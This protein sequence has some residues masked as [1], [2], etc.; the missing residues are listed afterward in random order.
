ML[1]CGRM[2]E[3]DRPARGAT[4]SDAD[5]T[6]LGVAPP[7]LESDAESRQRSPVFV[8]SGTSVADVEPAPLPRIALPS[9][10][11]QAAV[12]SEAPVALPARASSASA[13]LGAAERALQF[14]LPRPALWMVLA[15]TL[16]AV[17]VSAG[18]F[19]AGRGRAKATLSARAAVSSAA[20]TGPGSAPQV[21]PSRAPGTPG[22]T[23]TLSSA[24]FDELERRPAES[25]SSREVLA[26]AEGHA[27]R[28]GAAASA[29]RRKLQAHPALAKDPAVQVEL[30]HL[31]DDARTAREALAAM[32]AAEAPVGPDLLYQVW[33][34]TAVRTEATE[35]SR[36][37]VYS[38]DVRPHASP[39]LAV[40]LDLRLADQCQEYQAILPRALKD[41]DRRA[42]HLLN[43]LTNKRGCG[44]KKA[45]DCY[46]CLRDPKD[47]LSATLNAVKSRRA[48]SY[49]T[50]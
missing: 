32:L 10:P 44:P 2:S 43:K 40:A 22:A 34:G 12:G 48:P 19:A 38:N 49:A 20:A 36:A 33:T 35:L 11:P 14:T 16:F 6:L 28:Q 42:L 15:P 21:T 26:L 24:A 41:G 27:E 3:P 31:A 1:R 45:D 9:R 13:I 7:Q 47:E 17:L 39:A 30:L 5:R 8:R 23:E 46:A 37:L 4:Q 25:L 50:P 18:L 29:L